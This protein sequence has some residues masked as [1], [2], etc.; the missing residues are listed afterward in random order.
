M[1]LV[2]KSK[3]EYDVRPTS[4]NDSTPIEQITSA[5]GEI[6]NVVDRHI[7]HKLERRVCRKMD[8]R[9]LPFICIMYLFNAL[10]KGNISNAKTDTID[11]DLNIEGTEW[12]L[13]L[14]IFYIPFVLF[15]FPLSL[16]IKRFNAARV[17]PILVFTFGSITL[18]L[19][20]AFNFSCLMAGRFFL[21]LCESA[22]LP[23]IIFYL[24]CFYRRNELA[25]RLSVIYSFAAIA[26][27]FSGLL[28]F[29]CFQINDPNVAGWQILFLLEGS[30]TLVV[31][32]L[33][34]WILP[35]SVHTA[36]FFTEEEKEN[37]IFRI[38]TDSSAAQGERF[39][40]RDAIKVF[41]NPVIIAWLFEELCIGVPLNSI[42]N[43]FP[44]II[45][46]LGKLTVQTNLFT[47]APNIW[48]AL[49][50]LVFAFSS[51]YVRVRS[52]FLV[53]AILLT[54]VGFATYGGIDI[55]N[56]IAGAYV[57]CFLMTT[58]A[59]ASSVLT[60]TWYNNNTPNENRRVVV[61]AVGIPLANAAGLISTNIFRPSDAPKYVP[62]LGI[63]AGFGGLAILV[64]LS[65]VSFMIFDNKRRNKAQGV[66]LTYMDVPTTELREGPN[67]P[68]F[69]W[70][71]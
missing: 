21:G 54:V 2:S 4:S 39:E 43:W 47:V 69:R 3:T 66:N 35:R 55:E 59:S 53:A 29:G 52:G 5:N 11:E 68:S 33:A 51:D 46:A 64:V 41:K 60:S 1:S 56:N 16:V 14:S 26:N 7:D 30:L 38:T 45:Q 71:Y 28:A 42:N 37:A 17:L 25:S 61:S 20:S 67:S 27:A 36:K 48:G 63:T 24:S 6:I 58:G 34:F 65:I 12:N 31:A 40:F 62:A 18:L 49:C 50:L 19:V 13:M 9:I 15:A 57:A 8:I 32:G 23:G 44:Q 22:V 10:D 70:M